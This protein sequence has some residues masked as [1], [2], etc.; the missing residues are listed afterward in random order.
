MELKACEKFYMNYSA[1]CDITHAECKTTVIYIIMLIN[2]NLYVYIVY[3]C[4]DLI[5]LNLLLYFL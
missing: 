1:L 4:Y 2:F 5:Y 3:R